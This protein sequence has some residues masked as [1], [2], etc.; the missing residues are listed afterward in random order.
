MEKIK[1]YKYIIILTLIILGGV[2][3]WF[4]FRP[5]NIRSSCALWARDKAVKENEAE[6]GDN[7]SYQTKAYDDYYKRCLR[8]KGLN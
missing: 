5:S 7:K 1:Q 4:E 3:Y 8:E 6:T 2:F